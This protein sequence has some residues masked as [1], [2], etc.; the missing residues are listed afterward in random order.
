MK[1]DGQE[2][3]AASHARIKMSNGA[4]DLASFQ[5]KKDE[6]SFWVSKSGSHLSLLVVTV[7]ATTAT[8]ASV[9]P[10]LNVRC[11]FIFIFSPL[12]LSLCI[13]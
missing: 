1:I 8:V 3:K 6:H 5:A 9:Q 12:S 13:L 10:V 4:I 2:G 11:C 7:D